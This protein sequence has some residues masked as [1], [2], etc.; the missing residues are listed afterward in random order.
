MKSS[1][2]LP[3][4]RLRIVL[5]TALFARSGAW[6]KKQKLRPEFVLEESRTPR[7]LAHGGKSYFRDDSLRSP[8]SAAAKVALTG[9]GLPRS[10]LTSVRKTVC[11]SVEYKEAQAFIEN[12]HPGTV[13][14]CWLDMA[15]TP[16]GAHPSLKG[17]RLQK[18]RHNLGL[19]GRRFRTDACDVK[20]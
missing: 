6:L 19:L 14:P 4:S 2:A 16:K 18:H 15:P 9:G 20:R 11:V 12:Q 8:I 1:S 7:A 3:V 13:A 10:L 5:V 17:P